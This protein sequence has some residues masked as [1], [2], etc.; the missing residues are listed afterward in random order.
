MIF[1]NNFLKKFAKLIKKFG[2]QMPITIKIGKNWDF[3]SKI[4]KKI[5]SQKFDK[6]L[7]QWKLKKNQ[8]SDPEKIFM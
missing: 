4:Q 5:K 3:Q 1:G 2:Y 7:L 6:K 8:N